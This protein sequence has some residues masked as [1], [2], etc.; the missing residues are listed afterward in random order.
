V[1]ELRWGL[2]LP[3]FD[4]LR[5][6]HPPLLDAA[7]TAE[8]LGFDAIW[9]G[10]H[11]VSPAPVLDSLCCLSAAAA[12]TRRLELGI[13]VLQVGLRNAVVAAKQLTTVDALAPGRLR[14]GVGVGGEY[15]AEFEAAGVEHATRGRRLD[16]LL[17]VLPRLLGGERVDHDGP[18]LSVHADG[19]WPTPA[20]LPRL[21]VG[22]RS[23]AAV[24]RAARFADQWLAMWHDPATIADRA[25]RMAAYAAELGRPNPSVGLL[26]LV[27]VDDDE[28]RAW[29]GAAELI[30]GQY[31]LPLRAV[32]RWTLCG[33]AG[34]VARGLAA[35]G[36]AG[37]SEFVLMPAGPDP[38]RQYHRLAIVRR[39]VDQLVAEA[40]PRQ[41]GPRQT[42]PR[43]TGPRQTG[44]RQTGWSR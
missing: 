24:R 14:L 10:D 5:S 38:L 15:P 33:P 20:A 29:R 19:L 42:G 1:D 7:R 34:Q 35:F 26:V 9:V 40:R 8:A 25:A 32:R 22:G 2:L 39:M 21:S 17:T 30:A 3:T 37:V 16:E 4:P 36:H 12:V 44:P 28:E 43:Q 27:N 18:A 6:G 41:T 23:L 11:L 31:G 13:S